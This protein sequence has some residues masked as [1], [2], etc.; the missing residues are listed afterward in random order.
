MIVSKRT[1]VIAQSAVSTKR[2][3]MTWQ[4]LNG[5]STLLV[6]E[7]ANLGPA[8]GP[9]R[10]DA[11]RAGPENPGP[12]AFTGRN[13]PNDFLFKIPLFIVRWALGRNKGI[14]NSCKCVV[15]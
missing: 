10:A 7:M 9:K 4:K 13:G 12:R 14:M 15:Y 1:L 2:L 8:R 11:G 5:V 3:G 6:V